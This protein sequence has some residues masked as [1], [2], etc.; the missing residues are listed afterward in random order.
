M[1][2][3]AI[4]LA[5]AAAAW[6]QPKFE[7]ASIKPS[8]VTGVITHN[9]FHMTVGERML[10]LLRETRGAHLERLIV[11]NGGRVFF[12]PAKNVD[13]IEAQGNY[14]NLHGG[15]KSYLFREA[16]GSLEG[17]LD[18]GKFRRIQRSTIVN[19][20][21]IRE[22]RPRLHGDYEVVLRDGTVLKL[23]HRFRENLESNALGGL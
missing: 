7:V 18:R 15:G 19:I 14:V 10:A 3:T 2:K 21:A 9:Q 13:W 12:L 17:K 5:L 11:R 23:S 16:L 1:F 6:G 8:E 4:S 20:E 22:L